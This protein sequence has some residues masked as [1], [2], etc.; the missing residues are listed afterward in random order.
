MSVRRPPS[1]LRKR[2]RVE[3]LIV[4]GL[5]LGQSAV[6]AVVNLIDNLS[7]GPIAQATAT[8][9]T[10]KNN[11]EYFDLAYQLLGNFFA[12]IPLALVL[13]LLWKP[14]RSGFTAI[15]F[16]FAKPGR[17]LLWGVGLLVL[18]GAP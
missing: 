6:Y 14:A 8:L 11:R 18:I 10:S 5:S 9:N 1:A 16:T 4:L 13:Y 12:L 17:D 3:I 2:W 15:G 7:R